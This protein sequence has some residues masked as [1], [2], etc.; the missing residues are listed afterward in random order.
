M[1]SARK[2][3]ADLPCA[4]TRSSSLASLGRFNTS[5]SSST[6]TSSGSLSWERWFSSARKLSRSSSLSKLLTTRLRFPK[7]ANPSPDLKSMAQTSPPKSL[8][9]RRISSVFP[10]PVGPTTIRCGWL[11]P[12]RMSKGFPSKPISWWPLWSWL[13]RASVLSWNAAWNTLVR[14]LAPQISGLSGSL[15]RPR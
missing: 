6:T 7:L 11:G 14:T 4:A 3:F 1:A 8:A 12:G 9:T 15:L 10:Q 13:S 2:V 5:A